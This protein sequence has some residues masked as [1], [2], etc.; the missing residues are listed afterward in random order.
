MPDCRP[1]SDQPAEWYHMFDAGR[2]R[3]WEN[4]DH[5]EAWFVPVE[6]SLPGMDQKTVGLLDP[7]SRKRKYRWKQMLPA[8]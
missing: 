5:E 1:D 8:Y 2:F 7:S 3:L 4:I 6:E